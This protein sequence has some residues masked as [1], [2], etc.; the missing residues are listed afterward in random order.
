M[1]I[2][3]DFNWPVKERPPRKTAMRTLYYGEAYSHVVMPSDLVVSEKDFEKAK[4]DND[5]MFARSHLPFTW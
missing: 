5:P 4:G 3:K 2:S 1:E